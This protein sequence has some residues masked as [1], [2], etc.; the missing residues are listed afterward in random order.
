MSEKKKKKEVKARETWP[1]SLARRSLAR[2]SSLPDSILSFPHSR[3]PN[4]LSHQKDPAELGTKLYTNTGLGTVAF[5]SGDVSLSAAALAAAELASPPEIKKPGIPTCVTLS[6]PSM[7]LVETFYAVDF[8]SGRDRERK[9]E[10]ER[11]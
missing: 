9:R 8:E 2:L 3:Y 6:T 1:L 5:L 11:G 4:F 10:R 7:M